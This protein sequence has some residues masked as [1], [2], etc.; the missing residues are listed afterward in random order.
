[1]QYEEF[2]QVYFRGWKK[3]TKKPNNERRNEARSEF[4][5]KTGKFGKRLA[6]LSKTFNSPWVIVT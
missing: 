1:M 4:K 3:L 2:L 5:R 6:N